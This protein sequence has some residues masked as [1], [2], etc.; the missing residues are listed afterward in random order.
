MQLAVDVSLEDHDEAGEEE[1]TGNG[2]NGVAGEE[3]LVV[4]SVVVA[5]PDC[6]VDH[7]GE[8]GGE[9]LGHGDAQ[10]QREDG[11]D[12]ARRHDARHGRQGLRRSQ[13]QQHHCVGAH[14]QGVRRRSGA[15]H[16][17]LLRRMWVRLFHHL[18]IHS[19]TPCNQ[20]SRKQDAV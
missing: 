20:Y 15:A 18:R 2:E 11:A 3:H 9:P 6:D 10:E 4:A 16:L 19:Y 13:Q 1:Q 5:A 14:L 17:A 12:T 7:C 8:D